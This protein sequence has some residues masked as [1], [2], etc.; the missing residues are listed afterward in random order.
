MGSRTPF[1][2]RAI[3]S[4]QDTPP[5]AQEVPRRVSARFFAEAW[6]LP[7]QRVLTAFQNRFGECGFDARDWELVLNVG[8]MAAYELHEGIRAKVEKADAARAAA[9]A[10]SRTDPTAA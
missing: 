7:T 1:A 9:T 2:D 10:A 3:A 5:E 4:F 6:D 8:F